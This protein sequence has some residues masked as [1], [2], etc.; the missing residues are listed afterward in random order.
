MG[1]SKTSD[2]IQIKIKI[3]NPIQ[4]P[5]ASSK[6]PNDVLC[7]FKIKIERKHSENGCIKDQ[8]PYH[9]QYHYIKPQSW[10]FSNI[11]SPKSGV[12]DMDVLWPF[13]N[14]I[15]SRNSGHGC[16]KDLSTYPYKDWDAKSQSRTFRI[17]QCPK[18]ELTGCKCSLDLQKSRQ[19][20][21]DL[22][23]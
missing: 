12:H 23:T 18:S 6:A 2:Y 10:T 16:F 11:Q 3:P 4:E 1:I 14:K 7:T 15:D 9:N 19:G 8:W 5:P 22:G 21:K 20:Q 13:K 17:F